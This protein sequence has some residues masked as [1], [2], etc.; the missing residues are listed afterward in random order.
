MPKIVNI[1]SVFII[2]PKIALTI[3]FGGV[4]INKIVC[5]AKKC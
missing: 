2:C 3:P 1:M 5:G 4:I